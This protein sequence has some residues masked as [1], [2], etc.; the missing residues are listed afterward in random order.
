MRQERKSHF[1]VGE[2]EAQGLSQ[3]HLKVPGTSGGLRKGGVNP[4]PL[5]LGHR[6]AR[7][8]TLTPSV[9][10]ATSQLS[11]AKRVGRREG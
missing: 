7:P 9:L 11:S 5:R 8:E 6:G 10:L 2:T 1:A 3:P 4:L